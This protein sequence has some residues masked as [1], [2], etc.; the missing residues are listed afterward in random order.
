MSIYC[1]NNRASLELRKKGTKIG[2]RYDCF[3]K[4][5]GVGLNLDYD[6]TYS[7]RFVPIDAR[8]IYCGKLTRLPEGYHIM[9][10][11]PICLQKGIGVGKTLKAKKPKKTT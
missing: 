5:V 7:T 4:G 3:R 6:P 2:N 11:N 10:N 1:G 8:K 9:G